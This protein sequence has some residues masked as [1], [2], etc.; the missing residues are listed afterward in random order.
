MKTFKQFIT[1]ADTSSATNE[2][3]AI[4]YVYNKHQGMSHEE[5]LKEGIIT[6]SDFAKLTPIMLKIAEDIYLKNLSKGSR[7]SAMRM[8]GEKSG[9]NH[10]EGASDTTSK[11]DF[12]G[13]NKNHISLKQ[14]DEKSGAQL[15]S[16]KAAE[17]SGCVNA[18]ILHYENVDGEKLKKNKS[19]KK[20]LDTLENKMLN[21][22]RND[23]VVPISAGKRNITDWYINESGRHEALQ[24]KLGKIYTGKKGKN[25][26]IKHLKYEL[27]NLNALTRSKGYEKNALPEVAKSKGASASGKWKTE[28]VA[29]NAETL[30]TKIFPAYIKSSSGVDL[31]AKEGKYIPSDMKDKQIKK[32]VTELISTSVDSIEWKNDLTAFFETNNDLKKWVVFEAGSGL[33]K[34]TKEISNGKD[35]QGDNWRVANKMLVF[36]GGKGG[37]FNKEYVSIIKWSQANANLVNQ[38]DISYKGQKT[39]RYIK[40]GIPTKLKE[41][42]EYIVDGEMNSLNEEIEYINE[43]YLTE[44]I[45]GSAVDKIK[46]LGSAV[47]VYSAKIKNAFARFYENVIKKFMSKIRGLAESSISKFLDVIGLKVNA[48]L[49][50]GP[51]T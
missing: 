27:Q 39:S 17:A 46:G 3:M 45:F 29:P 14:S 36:R 48:R 30:K 24:K 50:L 40:F 15:I 4:V 5:A 44:G 37:G 11:S 33:Y 34:F 7:G 25:A 35:Y 47:S 16:S 6:P 41:G 9:P 2:E 32:Q 20:A 51:V 43:Q 8:A 28:L 1:E 49:E 31:S 21:S 26:I 18:A 42:I 12:Y 38:M 22:A 23:V 10:Y 13:N 19:Y